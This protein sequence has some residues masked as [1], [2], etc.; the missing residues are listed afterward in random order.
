MAQRNIVHSD[1]QPFPVKLPNLP[2][3]V[4][5]VIVKYSNSS[6]AQV[7]V[8]LSEVSQAWYKEAAADELWCV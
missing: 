8:K 4:I 5:R 1:T 6:A 3:D 2:T 7:L